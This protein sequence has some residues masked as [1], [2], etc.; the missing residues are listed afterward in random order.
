MDPGLL[1]IKYEALADAQSELASHHAAAQT[2]IEELK[3][4]L[5]GNLTQWTGEAREA[6]EQVKRDW[7]ATFA[8]MA[9]VLQKAHMHL[10]N[11]NEWY[12]AMERANTTMW[13]GGR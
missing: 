3:A 2:A 11:A 5:E 6:Y 4:K 13:N 12:Q 1:N 7:D 8:H 9:E 10:G